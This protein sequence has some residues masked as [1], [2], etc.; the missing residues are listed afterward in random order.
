MKPLLIVLFLLPG[1]AIHLVHAQTERVEQN[2]TSALDT[3]KKAAR[4]KAQAMKLPANRYNEQSQLAARQSAAFFYSPTFQE[5]IQ[6]EQNRLKKEVCKDCPT[7]LKKDKPTSEKKKPEQVIPP[8]IRGK[9]YLCLSASIPDETVHSYLAAITKDASGNITPV[10]RGLI[11][12]LQNTRAGAD[13]FSQIL[14]TDQ[15]CRDTREPKK[16]CQRFKLSIRINQLLFARYT[17]TR[18][19]AL[20]YENEAQAVI[21]QGDARLGYLLE[22]VNNALVE[23][24]P[25]LTT[26]AKNMRGEQ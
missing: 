18:V 17:I 21:I 4:E 1:T 8:A 16:I 12:G 6:S 14:K 15:G 19:P 20:V 5:R 13:Y 2:M 26:L 23:E 10:M 25:A 7:F 3:I 24:D 9:L 22:R 11:N